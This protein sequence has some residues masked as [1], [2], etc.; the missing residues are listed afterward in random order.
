LKYYVIGAGA[1][2]KRHHQNLL[3]L[4]AN[5]VLLGWR[6][7]NLSNF[8]QQL[9]AD[10]EPSAIVVATASQIRLQIIEAAAKADAP[11]YVEKPIAYRKDELDRIYSCATPIIER[12]MVGFMMR[13]HPVVRDLAKRDH[14]STFGFHFEIGH[15]V[16]QWRTNWS[17]ANSYA[18]QAEGGGVILDLCHEIDLAHL[19]FP[20]AK[21]QRVDCLGHPDFAGV[22]VASRLTLAQ[23]NGPSGTVTMDYLSP[24]SIR[25]IG[26]RSIGNVSDIDLLACTETRTDGKDT[27]S[28]SLDFERNE[29]FVDIMQDFMT[30]AETGQRPK[31]PIAPVMDQVYDSCCLIADAWENRVFHGAIAGGMT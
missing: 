1:I 22:D 15:D 4:G 17:F 7:L 24:Q 14:A 28:S 5:V 20:K 25:R 9:E 27:R 12:S 16:R 8:I 31:N 23:P 11:V 3:A 6:D 30:L 19:L 26:L 10:A 21:L 29:M 2:G 18:A 13:Y